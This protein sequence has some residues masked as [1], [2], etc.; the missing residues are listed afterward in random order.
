MSRAVITLP[1]L[2]LLASACGSVPVKRY[3]A[4]APAASPDAGSTRPL[5]RLPLVVADVYAPPPFDQSKLVFR[6]DPYEI[7][8]YNYRFW[9]MKPHRMVQ[10]LLTE[11]LTTRGLFARVERAILGSAKRLVLRTTVDAMGEE[12]MS[13]GS[14]SAHLAMRFSLEEPKHDRV[15]WQ[16]R[17]DQRLPLPEDHTAPDLVAG[18]SDIFADGSDAMLTALAAHLQT[19]PLCQTP[20]GSTDGPGS[21]R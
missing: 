2:M 11:R 5:C 6:T 1:A 21:P 8:F 3:Y 10:R 14:A 15:L 19:E 12:T 17:F 9:V 4:L 20:D 7:K 18:L 13:E 16:Y